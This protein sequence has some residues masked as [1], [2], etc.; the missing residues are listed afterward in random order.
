MQQRVLGLGQRSCAAPVR[1]AGAHTALKANALTRDQASDWFGWR[2]GL[3][4]PTLA[5][6]VVVR[7][8]QQVRL[9]AAR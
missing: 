6:A 9:R 7:A 4:R 2:A 8:Q 3:N 1:P 5:R